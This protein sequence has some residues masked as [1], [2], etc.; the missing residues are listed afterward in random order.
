MNVGLWLNNNMVE[1]KMRENIS[2]SLL[3]VRERP[4]EDAQYKRKQEAEE[5][6]G[7]VNWRM[8]TVRIIYE[9]VKRVAQ[10]A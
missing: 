3:E 1:G 5:L 2:R 6:T 10:F 9:A 4:R 7:E 8:D